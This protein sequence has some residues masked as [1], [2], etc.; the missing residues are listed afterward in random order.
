M[1]RATGL[2]V[3]ETRTK[4]GGMLVRVMGATRHGFLRQWEGEGVLSLGTECHLP[5]KSL[6]AFSTKC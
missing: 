1:T 5:L 4:Q 6:Q 3:V 2:S